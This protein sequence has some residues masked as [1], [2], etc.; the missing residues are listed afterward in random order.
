[1]MMMVMIMMMMMMMIMMMIEPD[2]DTVVAVQCF[3]DIAAVTAAGRDDDLDLRELEELG[4]LPAE[5]EV[6]IDNLVARLISGLLGL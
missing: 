3:P 5:L 6:C 1:M 4:L 2:S